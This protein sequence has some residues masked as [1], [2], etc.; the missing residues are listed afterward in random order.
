MQLWITSRNFSHN[1]LSSLNKLKHWRV[2]HESFKMVNK[3]H[4][5]TRSIPS[6]ISNK[7]NI[8]ITEKKTKNWLR[9]EWIKTLKNSVR[10]CFF[11]IC[12]DIEWDCLLLLFQGRNT[13]SWLLAIVLR[14]MILAYN[15]QQ[16][17]IT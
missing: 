14:I 11:V 6:V 17:N 8:N 13:L 4:T 3:S 2:S 7:N 16:T 1:K 9:E 12:C 10:Y 15:K 5:H